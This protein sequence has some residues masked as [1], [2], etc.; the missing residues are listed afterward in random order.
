MSKNSEYTIANHIVQV[1]H[2]FGYEATL[3]PASPPFR[4][5]GWFRGRQFG[6]DIVVRHEN[7]SAVVVVKSRPAVMYDV[8]ITDQLRGKKET[9]ALICVS[10]AS[11]RRI[12]DSAT[13]YAHELDVRLCS[14][15][16]VG[17]ILRELLDSPDRW[18]PEET[19]D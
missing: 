14:L 3:E 16:G 13:D 11:F 9:G 2:E 7:R 10:D 18:A 15:S 1:A 17:D 8:F 6:P 19:Y 4:I 12:R 5:F